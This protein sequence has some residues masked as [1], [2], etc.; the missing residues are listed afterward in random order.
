MTKYAKLLFSSKN[1]IPVNTQLATEIGLNETIVLRQVYYWIEHNEVENINFRDGKYWVYN[2]MKQ[3]KED[4]F[5][6]FSEKTIERAF[7]SLRERNII[8]VGDYSEIR[9]KRPNWYTINDDELEKLLKK[10]TGEEDE[11]QEDKLPE[12]NDSSRYR[13]NDGMET[14]N[15]TEPYNNIYNIYNN[16]RDYNTEINEVNTLP[17]DEDKV[18]VDTFSPK[19]PVPKPPRKK[20]RSELLELQADMVHRFNCIVGQYDATDTETENIC[21][22]FRLYMEK[23]NEL[24]GKVHPILVNDTLEDV[25]LKLVAIRDDE[26]DHFGNVADRKKG[27]NEYSELEI[28]VLEHFRR[29]HNKGTDYHITHFANNIE[30]LKKLADGI[31]EY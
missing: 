20:S 24:T 11:K 9:T 25:F 22:A 31:V 14:D 6:F 12:E 4:N 16:N 27:D 18:K 3:W 26:H 19:K 23:Y 1:N 10:V 5:P 8:I 13:Q 29:K 15:V 30:Y 2:S 7:K 17:S 21:N 28:M